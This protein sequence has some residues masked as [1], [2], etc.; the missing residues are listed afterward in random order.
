MKTFEQEF[1]NLCKHIKGFEEI[2]QDDIENFCLDK[3]KVREE[4][5]KMEKFILSKTYENRAYK[6]ANILHRID[7]LR[8]RFKL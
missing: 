8:K 1:P 7:L 2:S 4:I 6:E 3:Q 5:D